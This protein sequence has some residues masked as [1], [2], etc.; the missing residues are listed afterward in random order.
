MSEENVHHL[1]EVQDEP[2][3]GIVRQ[4]EHLLVE[5]RAGRVWALGWAAV[6]RTPNGVPGV[7]Q[8]AVVE[9]QYVPQLTFG[10]RDLE[11]S[12]IEFCRQNAYVQELDVESPPEGSDD[13]SG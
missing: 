7:S 6:T 12:L 4:L 9:T 2:H 13:E 5:A 11:L 1:Q 10:L 3:D 8:S